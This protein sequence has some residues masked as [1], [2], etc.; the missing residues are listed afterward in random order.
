M[1]KIIATDSAIAAA[2]EAIVAE[3]QEPAIKAIQERIGG[4]SFTT[5][6]KGL[7]R[8]RAEREATSAVPTEIQDR[9]RRFLGSIWAVASEVAQRDVD[10]IRAQA[11][12]QVAQV[13]KDLDEARHEIARLE[14]ANAAQ[15]A[16]LDAQSTELLANQEALTQ[17][18][19]QA[20]RLPV[21]EQELADARAEL[22]TLRT[23]AEDRGASV[24]R[25]TAERDA[26]QAQVRDLLALVRPPERSPSEDPG[27]APAT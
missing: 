16:R 5:V 13:G 25:L 21:L 23:V 7:E 15:E 11:H 19:I 4:G 6:A 17:A 27:A 20:A 1:S 2:I 14:A 3:G 26:A 12:D 8:W 18:R 9:T 22:K 10:A 24:A